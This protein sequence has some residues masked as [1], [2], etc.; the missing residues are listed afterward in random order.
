MADINKTIEEMIRRDFEESL[1]NVGIVTS[2]DAYMDINSYPCR[3]YSISFNTRET[4]H[5]KK[6]IYNPPATIILWSDD[7]KTVA[8]CNQDD[9]Y[10]PEAGFAI[11]VAKKYRNNYYKDLNKSIIIT[12]DQ[13]DDYYREY[14]TSIGERRVNLSRVNHLDIDDKFAIVNLVPVK[15]FSKLRKNR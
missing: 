14:K 10:S 6:V 2:A 7:T 13:W 5:I 9:E 4:I 3:P 12:Q 8:K 11:C 15:D 1:R